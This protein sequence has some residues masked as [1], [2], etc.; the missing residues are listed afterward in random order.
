M[1]PFIRFTF[2]SFQ[3]NSLLDNGKVLDISE[4]KKHIVDGI[5]FNWLK[6]QFGND[7]DI[8]LYTSEDKK[9]IIDFFQNLVDAVNEKRKF[10]VQNNGISLLLAY[11]IEGI[12]QLD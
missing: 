6:S 4:T 3:L 1:K 5:I 2:L 9:I 12:Q 11:C 7:I 8:S 10:G